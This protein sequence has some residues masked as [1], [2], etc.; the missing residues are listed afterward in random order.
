MSEKEL[1]DVNEEELDNGLIELIDEEG[2]VI[3]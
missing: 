1:N 2:K 3:N